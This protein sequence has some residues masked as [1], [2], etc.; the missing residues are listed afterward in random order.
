MQQ[1]RLLGIVLYFCTCQ[2][3]SADNP[4]AATNDVGHAVSQPTSRSR[5]R[6]GS[7]QQSCITHSALQWERSFARRAPVTNIFSGS[8]FFLCFLP[9]STFHSRPATGS[10]AMTSTDGEA[11]LVMFRST[12]GAN[13]TRKDYWG[14]DADLSRWQGVKVNGQG[15]VVGLSLMSNN[16]QGILDP[17]C[18][19][20]MLSCGVNFTDGRAVQSTPVFRLQGW[21]SG[22]WE[23]T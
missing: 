6:V 4:P 8:F 16:L 22:E 20:V 17:H 19:H 23:M 9:R 11:L 21:R 14:T 1:P 10:L 3:M 12:G 2:H 18:R 13:W 15:R 7:Q 5:P